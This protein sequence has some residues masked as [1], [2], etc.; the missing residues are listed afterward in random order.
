[1]KL[2]T[3]VD[4]LIGPESTVIENDFV[5]IQHLKPKSIEVV[6]DNVGVSIVELIELWQQKG[7]K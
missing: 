6:I 5:E 1:M 7:T 2:S 4:I 3:K